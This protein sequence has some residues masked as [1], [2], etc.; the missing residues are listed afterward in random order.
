MNIQVLY[1]VD[2]VIIVYVVCMFNQQLDAYFQYMSTLLL[3]NSYWCY[4]PWA[5]Q[6]GGRMGPGPGDLDLGTHPGAQTQG[7]GPEYPGSGPGDPEPG[8]EAGPASGSLLLV[9][10]KVASFRIAVPHPFQA[11][12]P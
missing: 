12:D 1:S 9:S 6:T 8:P 3:I 10:V 2:C 11:P 7:P 4:E 5:H